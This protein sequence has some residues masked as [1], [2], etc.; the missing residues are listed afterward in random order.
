MSQNETE[1]PLNITSI[2][3]KFKFSLSKSIKMYGGKRLTTKRDEI[4]TSNEE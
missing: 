4:I 1:E 2:L 3:N